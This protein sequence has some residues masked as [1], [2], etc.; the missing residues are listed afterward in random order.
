MQRMKGAAWILGLA[1][2]AV[3][4]ASA[5]GALPAAGSYCQAAT[6]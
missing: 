2:G 6:P 1:A 5:L 3:A 4:G